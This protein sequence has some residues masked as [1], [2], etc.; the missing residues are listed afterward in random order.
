CSKPAAH[1][2]IH[3][4]PSSLRLRV[5]ALIPATATRQ[6]VLDRKLTRPMN[7]PSIAH[8]RILVLDFGAQYAQLI[9]RRVREN[10][11]YCENVRH[12]ITPDQIRRHKPRGLILSGGASRG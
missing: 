9:S 5:F 7:S 6:F 3:L 8:Q 10:N 2:K 12:D 4:C 1:D 11:V